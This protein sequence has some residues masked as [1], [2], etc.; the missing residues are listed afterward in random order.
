[1]GI[2]EVRPEATASKSNVNAAVVIVVSAKKQQLEHVYDF[3]QWENGAVQFFTKLW[4]EV[5]FMLVIWMI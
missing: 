2:N 5:I 1:M 3:G 4:A